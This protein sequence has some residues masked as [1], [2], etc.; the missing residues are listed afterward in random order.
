MIYGKKD[1][2]LDWIQRMGLLAVKIGQIHALR[3]DFLP[4]EK[5]EEL[6]K[7][8]RKNVVINSEDL[9]KNVDLSIFNS[10]DYNPIATASV[11]QVY[12][13]NLKSGED[14]VL[15]VIKKDF[16]KDFIQD[17]KSIRRFLT[18][19]LLVYPKLK[20]VFDPMGILKHIEEYTLRE[21][22]MCKEIE[23]QEILKKIYD[24][25]QEYFNKLNLSFPAI[26]KDISTANTLIS[27]YIPGKTFD[28][29]LEEGHL[30]YEALLNFFRIHGYYIFKKGVFH[31]DVHP[32]NIMLSDDKMYFIDTGAI[33]YVSKKISRNL[34]LFFEALTRYD[35]DE[36]AVHINNMAEKSLN[37]IQLNAFKKKM[38]I[39]YE[40]FK[41]KT[42]AEASLT[43]KM[44]ETIKTAVNSGMIFEKGMFGIIKSFMFLDGMVLRCK[45]DALLIKDMRPYIEA[46]L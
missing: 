18:A 41:D 34:L 33:S 14:V 40:D 39:I 22:D 19:Q 29:L 4:T 7:L 25:N 8:Y 5:C 23:G 17:V 10:F 44:M 42:V 13:A 46:F 32:G 21:L 16:K 15:K 3:L 20:K 2:D 6:A 43:R 11:A 38:R 1:I 45:P 24:E 35:Y 12:R 37:K 27:Q 30:P 9:L 26:H 28:E 31:G 36:G